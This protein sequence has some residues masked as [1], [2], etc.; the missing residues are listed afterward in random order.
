MGRQTGRHKYIW[1]KQ[2]DKLIWENRDKMKVIGFG[3]RKWH[4]VV[5][6]VLAQSVMW[7]WL[8]MVYSLNYI[9][10]KARAWH[11][12][13]IQ[14]RSA[15]SHYTMILIR[16][17]ATWLTRKLI[18]SFQLPVAL[19]GTFHGDSKVWAYWWQTGFYLISHRFCNNA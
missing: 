7:S 12:V 15:I 18:G 8:V 3:T 19:E 5:Y 10:L 6:L 9:F 17:G 16:S 4:H 11:H 1:R 14:H 13:W 2:G